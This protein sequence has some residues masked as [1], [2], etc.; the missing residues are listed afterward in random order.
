MLPSALR[1][2]DVAPYIEKVP[3]TLVQ[4]EMVPVPGGVVE[5][6]TPAGPRMVSVPPFWIAKTEVTWDL[7]DVFVHGLDR[8]ADAGAADAVSRPTKPYMLPGEQFGHQ[9][10]PA[11]GMS[12]HA[13][14]QLARWLSAVTGKKYAVPNEAQWELACRAGLGGAADAG[15]RAWHGGNS[16]DRT[17][18]VATREPDALG[19]HD[20]LGNVAEWV[21]GVD[22]DSVAKGGAFDVAPQDVHC[23]ARM[24]QT[25]AWNVTDPQLPKSPWWLPDAYFLGV[26]LIR[27]MESNP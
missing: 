18:A 7:Y 11:L 25:P 21:R 24:R 22:G 13:A 16:E 3:G 8:P 4:I 1:A 9:G 10:L 15:A 27:V 23:G 14:N 17:H 6:V 5:M 20:L 19:V 2:Q 12:F 26:R